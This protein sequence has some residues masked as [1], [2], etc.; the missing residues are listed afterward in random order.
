MKQEQAYY[1]NMLSTSTTVR[2][3][4]RYGPQTLTL[5]R[6]YYV[7]AAYTTEYSTAACTVWYGSTVQPSKLHAP[8]RSLC[9]FMDYGTRTLYVSVSL[10]SLSL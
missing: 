5:F 3:I 8:V 9:S 6:K 4:V 1:D 7:Y 2:S 10:L